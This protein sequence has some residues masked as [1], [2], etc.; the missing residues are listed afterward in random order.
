MS[1][2]A[3]GKGVQ[4]FR[5]ER[6]EQRWVVVDTRSS[7]VVATCGSGSQGFLEA[8]H[9]AEA[10]NTSAAAVA[11]ARRVSDMAW[12]RDWRKAHKLSQQK[13]AEL[14]GV[15]WLTVQRWE[16][17]HISAPPYLHYTLRGLE[18][19]LSHAE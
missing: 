8:H 11:M 1:T 16:A 7:E 5:P 9:A 13:L 2:S 4:I 19:E 10:L 6:H 3:P 18:Q 15:T 14:L 17:G 12:L